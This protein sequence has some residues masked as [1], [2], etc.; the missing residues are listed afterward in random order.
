MSTINATASHDVAK[1]LAAKG[2]V[3]ATVLGRRAIVF[4]QAWDPVTR[5]PELPPYTITARLIRA[6][7]EDREAAGTP[8]A[9]PEAQRLIDGLNWDSWPT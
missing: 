5:D 1:Q 4:A 9:D 3:K 2:A 8:E 6:D 7:V